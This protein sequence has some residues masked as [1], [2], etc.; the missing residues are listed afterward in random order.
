MKS[1]GAVANELGISQSTVKRWVTAC[2]MK[3]H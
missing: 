1:S 2:N 3:G